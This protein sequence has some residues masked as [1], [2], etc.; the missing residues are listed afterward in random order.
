NVCTKHFHLLSEENQYLLDE[1]RDWEK[2]IQDEQQ[3]N[4][5][6]YQAFRVMNDPAYDIFS[7]KYDADD[8]TVQTAVYVPEEMK[9][10]CGI[11]A[12]RPTLIFDFQQWLDGKDTAISRIR[13]KVD[14]PGGFAN[15]V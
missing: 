3:H 15:M 14:Y 4:T 6:P 1:S 8:R 10:W 13:G 5:N 12:D 7:Y 11:G 9:A 2:A